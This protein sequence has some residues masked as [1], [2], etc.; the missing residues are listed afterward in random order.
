MNND[1]IAVY[2][3]Q[4]EGKDELYMKMYLEPEVCEKMGEISSRYPEGY[5]SKKQL[6]LLELAEEELEMEQKEQK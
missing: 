1:K 6:D 5:W 2:L 3:T 4:G